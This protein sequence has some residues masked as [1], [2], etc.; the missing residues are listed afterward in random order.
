MTGKRIW[1]TVANHSPNQVGRAAGPEGAAYA[2]AASST[3]RRAFPDHVD[4]SSDDDGPVEKAKRILRERKGQQPLKK[5]QLHDSSSDDEIVDR[6]VHMLKAEGATASAHM[7]KHPVDPRSSESEEEP[8]VS[9]SPEIRKARSARVVRATPPSDP[10]SNIG[11]ESLSHVE[12]A[13]E[14]DMWNKLVA[15]E[16]ENDSDIHKITEMAINERAMKKQRDVETSPLPQPPAASESCTESSALTETDEDSPSH[17]H[18]V[19]DE[20]L[21]PPAA[22]WIPPDA[23]AVAAEAV[24]AE[25]ANNRD[26]QVNW[27]AVLSPTSGKELRTKV[28]SARPTSVGEWMQIGEDRESVPCTLP[29]QISSSAPRP[30]PSSPPIS[31]KASMVAL[32]NPGVVAPGD[33]SKS[34]TLSREQ[35]QTR[36]Q[37]SRGEGEEST[38]Q[39]PPRKPQDAKDDLLLMSWDDKAVLVIDAVV[40]KDTPQPQKL[41]EGGEDT[42]SEAR[43]ASPS[44]TLPSIA[45][46]PVRRA[47]R[48]SAPPAP[49]PEVKLTAT[50]PPS[51]TLQKIVK[52]PEQKAV[53]AASPPPL[54]LDLFQTP[55]VSWTRVPLAGSAESCPSD[56]TSAKIV[57]LERYAIAAE[58][59]LTYVD[60]RHP[61]A[62]RSDIHPPSSG[63]TSCSLSR[64]EFCE[65]SAQS[66]T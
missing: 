46:A 48:A 58:G 36:R 17:E 14:L 30:L 11:V 63:R 51:E 38:T 59:A 42:E 34:T 5:K 25:A 62:L 7:L 55:Q 39:A 24:A 41:A 23:R 61:C 33:S 10:S 8:S 20:A 22:E 45:K 37:R 52:V 35:W 21:A 64:M 16:R 19:I 29:P 56:S 15:D 49:L 26:A 9:P 32:N 1:P 2:Y 27:L 44:E 13:A 31:P 4:S 18:H 3:R 28:V 12:L 65:K 47:V 53:R 50:D 6:A 43:S 66:T 60:A 40:K 57:S 54:P